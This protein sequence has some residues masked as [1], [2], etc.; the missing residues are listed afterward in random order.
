MENLE[1][2]IELSVFTGWVFLAVPVKDH[3]KTNNFQFPPE[4][5]CFLAPKGDF[6]NLH[7][8]PLLYYLKKGKFWLDNTN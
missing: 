6:K 3:F 2:T 7:F 1:V 4:N 8:V 5:C